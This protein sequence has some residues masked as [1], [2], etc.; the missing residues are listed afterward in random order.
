MKNKFENFNLESSAEINRENQE[1][2]KEIQD[3]YLFY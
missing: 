1:F 2:K 3:F